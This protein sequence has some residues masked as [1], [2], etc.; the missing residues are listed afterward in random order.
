MWILHLSPYECC[1]VKKKTPSLQ[2]APVRSGV[3]T[4]ATSVRT[5]STVACVTMWTE[6]VCAPQDSW[7]RAVRQ[8][9][10]TL[11]TVSSKGYSG[12]TSVYVK[13]KDRNERQK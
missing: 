12:C 2:T 10:N 8:V 6:T 11:A 3:L 1:K 13:Q 9:C 5:V 4:V 7:E